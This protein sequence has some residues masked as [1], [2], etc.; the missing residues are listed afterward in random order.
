MKIKFVVVFVRPRKWTLK[1]VLSTLLGMMSLRPRR[2][3]LKD[4]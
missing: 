3:K 1:K 4:S 2:Q